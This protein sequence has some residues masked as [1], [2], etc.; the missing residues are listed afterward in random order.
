M[1]MS[2]HCHEVEAFTEFE[3]LELA[4]DAS[5]SAGVTLQPHVAPTNQT[6]FSRSRLSFHNLRLCFRHYL[7]NSTYALH[8]AN[9]KLL[10]LLSRCQVQP[11]LTC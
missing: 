5:Q 4:P 2:G 10:T 8:E 7:Q 1:V 9:W 11:H 6:A 3:V